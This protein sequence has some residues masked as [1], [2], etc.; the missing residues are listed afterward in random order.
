MPGNEGCFEVIATGSSVTTVA[1]GDW[2]IPRVPGLGT[3]RTHLQV[4]ADSV[5]RIDKEGLSHL[6]VATISVNPVTAW[7]LLTD[8]VDL[9]QCW[10]IQSGATGG[11]GRV[12]LQLAKLWGFKNIS[13]IRDGPN[14]SSTSQLKKHLEGLGATKVFTESEIIGPGFKK[15]VEGLL[16]G[17]KLQLGLDCVGGNMTT[18]IS[19]VLSDGAQLVTYGNMSRRP[20]RIGARSMIFHDIV[21]CGFW[22][23]RWAEE[24]VEE[25][26]KTVHNLLALYRAGTLHLPRI[27][28][29][30]WRWETPKEYLLEQISNTFGEYGKAKDFFVFP[31]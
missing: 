12:V 19:T 9:R 21:Y 30:P 23:S 18:K 27:S 1:N 10:F 14:P 13:I 17:E 4:N 7:R 28:T 6:H 29:H 8:F 11:V 31:D 24:H 3:W 25:K 20:I 16:K 15:L 26:E 2:V 5:T 22:V